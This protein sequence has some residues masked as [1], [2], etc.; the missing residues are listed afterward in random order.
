MFRIKKREVNGSTTVRTAI[1]ASCAAM[2]AAL[3]VWG[4]G[5]ALESR[6]PTG[7]APGNLRADQIFLQREP[8][9]VV[10]ERAGGL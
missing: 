4:K 5:L 6:R 1:P 10:K 8:M 2:T 3:S 9:A 7:N